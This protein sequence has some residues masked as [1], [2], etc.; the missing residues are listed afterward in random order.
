MRAV[1]ASCRSAF[2][3]KAAQTHRHP[4]SGC[5]CRYMAEEDQ[6]VRPRPLRKGFFAWIMPTWKATEDEV[7][8][9]SGVDAAM[10][11]RIFKYGRAALRPPS[12]LH[13]TD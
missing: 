4:T 8:L 13:T 11:L 7:V 1:Q 3:C 6:E 2:C 9:V 12:L 5:L 10:Y